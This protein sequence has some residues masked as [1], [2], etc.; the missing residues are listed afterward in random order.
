[1]N[2]YVISYA[3]KGYYSLQ[4]RFEKSLK[5]RGYSIYSYSDRWL[6]KQSFYHHNIDIL[7]QPRGGGYWLW[8]P[9]I[10]RDRLQKMN[11]GDL[12]F[13]CDVDAV[14]VDN[15]DVLF[16]LCDKN[17][18]LL[19]QNT[20]KKNVDWT[21]RDCFV[22]MDADNETYYNSYQVIGGMIFIKKTKS[23]VDFI[24]LWIKYA[25]DYRILTDSPNEL[26]FD[27]F[28]N[29]IE[30]RHDQSILGI[31][32][33]KQNIE[34]FR[35][36]TEYGNPYKY[37]ELRDV[38]EYLENGNYDDL[39]VFNNSSYRT[40]LSLRCSELEKKRKI[41]KLLRLLAHLKPFVC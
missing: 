41:D 22:L 31:L 1:M 33:K 2:K 10:I 24:D 14:A 37:P 25:T 17:E 19:F 15:L 36:P 4:N 12:L 27:N 29:F 3:S 16:D 21:K 20:F 9:F 30:H 38:E 23:N 28:D 8:K 6:R 34:L 13:Y 26:G 39:N 40:V 7:K 11:Y 35:D 5:D 18:L 32:A